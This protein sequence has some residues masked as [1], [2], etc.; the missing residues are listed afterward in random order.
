MI[1]TKHLFKFDG[2]TIE[3]TPHR[4]K[5]VRTS[6]IIVDEDSIMI[7]LQWTNQCRR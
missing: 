4:S 7:R 3:Y 6:E 2:E 1:V 5:R